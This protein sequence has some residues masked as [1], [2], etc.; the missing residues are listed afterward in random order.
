MGGGGGLYVTRVCWGYGGIQ[1][2][3]MMALA[4]MSRFHVLLE[5]SES[6]SFQIDDTL[7]LNTC[8]PI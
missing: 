1:T 4:S 3:S 7:E 5:P 8:S 6:A 2:N